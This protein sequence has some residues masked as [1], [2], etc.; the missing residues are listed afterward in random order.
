MKAFAVGRRGILKDYVDLYF[1]LKEKHSTL[2]RIK[3]LAE[4]K[5]DDFNFRLFL[6]QLFYLEDVREKEEEIE[7]LK[8]PVTKKEMVEFFE[9]EIKKSKIT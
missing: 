8:K 4:K 9:K 1:I 7:F 3:E 2:K 5:Y 6:E